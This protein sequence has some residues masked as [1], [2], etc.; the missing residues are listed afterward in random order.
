MCGCGGGRLLPP[1]NRFA[2]AVAKKAAIE[3]RRAAFW[4]AQRQ[5]PPPLRFPPRFINK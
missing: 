2:I 3:K 1:A 4:R 5:R